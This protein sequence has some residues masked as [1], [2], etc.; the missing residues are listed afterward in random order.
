[1]QYAILQKS[2]NVVIL[3]MYNSTEIINECFKDVCDVKNCYVFLPKIHM[4]YIH[5]KI[6][7]S[8]LM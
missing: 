4:K 5:D 3:Y 6:I 1:M 7:L 2:I 8:I